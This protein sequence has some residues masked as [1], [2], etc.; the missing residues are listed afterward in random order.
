MK[1]VGEKK[2]S[3]A[4]SHP[5]ECAVSINYLSAIYQITLAFEFVYAQ[6]ITRMCLNGETFW[7]ANAKFFGFF[8]SLW[9]HR[10]KFSTVNKNCF[11]LS[12]GRSSAI[13]N[14]KKLA[15]ETFSKKGWEHFHPPPLKIH[16]TS[17]TRL[18]TQKKRR[19]TEW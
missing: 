14:E 3:S 10:N 17:R 19:L 15:S 1:K 18:I 5:L 9:L 13:C 12:L 16:L 2:F 4:F 8:F 11:V 6:I 7:R